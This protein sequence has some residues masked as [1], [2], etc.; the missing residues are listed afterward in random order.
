M[1]RCT[2][3]NSWWHSDCA[4]L[5]IDEFNMIGGLAGKIIWLCIECKEEYINSRKE[6]NR[7]GELERRLLAQEELNKVDNS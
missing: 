6:V 5:D 2:G 7:E 3:C 1:L 4:R